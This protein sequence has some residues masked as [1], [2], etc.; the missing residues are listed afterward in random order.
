MQFA[1]FIQPKM[2]I[3]LKK[4]VTRKMSNVHSKLTNL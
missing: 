1:I 4:F 3:K 2:V